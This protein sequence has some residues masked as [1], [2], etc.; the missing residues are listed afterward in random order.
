[1]SRPAGFDRPP[2]LWDAARASC[3]SWPPP[4]G[5]GVKILGFGVWGF[6]VWSLG[7][8]VWDLGCRVE[9]VRCRVQGSESRVVQGVVYGV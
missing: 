2:R 5:F 9:D 6:G 3:S 8:R 1:M 7:F 4:V